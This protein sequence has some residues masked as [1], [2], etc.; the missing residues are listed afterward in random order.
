MILL[1]ALLA[2]ALRLCPDHV[3][4][5]CEQQ[6]VQWWAQHQKKPVSWVGLI[7]ILLLW[8]TL[9]GL[10]GAWVFR[11]GFGASESNPQGAAL[12]LRTCAEF[13]ARL[14]LICS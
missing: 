1:P 12:E 2:L 5:E 9:A 4:I 11:D 13:A 3:L 10:L 7:G 8:L 6:S 14:E